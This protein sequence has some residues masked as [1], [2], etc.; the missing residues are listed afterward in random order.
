MDKQQKDYLYYHTGFM[1]VRQYIMK[2]ISLKNWLIL[3]KYKMDKMF[4]DDLAIQLQSNINLFVQKQALHFAERHLKI[5]AKE[6]KTERFLHILW[7]SR[8]SHPYEYLNF[9]RKLD[10]L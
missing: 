8:T 6:L 4:L 3:R 2:E 9:Y 1:Y 10:S 7:F 5:V